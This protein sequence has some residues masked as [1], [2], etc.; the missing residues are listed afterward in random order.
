MKIQQ[1]HHATQLGRLAKI[2]KKMRIFWQ[3][4]ELMETLKSHQ[5]N[6][7]GSASFNELLSAWLRGWDFD[8]FEN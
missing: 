1:I 3:D 7:P 8:N 6:I 4:T 5:E 2:E